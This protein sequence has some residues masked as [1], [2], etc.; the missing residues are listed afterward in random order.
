[1]SRTRILFLAPSMAGGGSERVFAHILKHVDRERFAPVLALLEKKGPFLAEIPEDVDVIDLDAK[2]AR[3]ALPRVVR[4]V[5]SLRPDVVFSTMGY[6][7][8]SVML[9]R[10]FLPRKVRLI[11]RESNSPTAERATGNSPR[12][13][14]WL[15]R[16]LYRYFDA[17]VCQSQEM[18]D[19]LV[20]GYAVP[21]AKTVVI[22][23]PVDVERI[24]AQCDAASQQPSPLVETGRVRLVTMGRLVPQKGFDLLFKALALLVADWVDV[25]LTLLGEGRDE[26]M[27]RNL[28]QELGVADRVTFAG[29]QGAPVPYMAHADMYVLSSRYEGFPNAVLE[30]LACGTPVAA[31]ACPGGLNEIVRP[32]LNGCLA[33]PEDPADL[34]RCIKDVWR[35]TFDKEAMRADMA[36]RYA[37]P[38]MVQRY[39][40]LFAA[41]AGE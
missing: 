37:L 7:N 40:A 17:I 21:A 30:A 38:V 2:R 8:L 3:Y 10:P 22:N 6:M 24:A 23:N 4:C 11:A 12:Y 35:A 5:R 19:D 27:L 39:E 26:G 31:F 32:G 33:R 9:C 34:A 14:P 20:Q 15:Y 25:Q 36:A 29:F 28:A 18:C 41:V 1:M 16:R 13:Y